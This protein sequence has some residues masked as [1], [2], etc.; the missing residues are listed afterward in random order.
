MTVFV[1]GGA[2]ALAILMAM[3]HIAAAQDDFA[4]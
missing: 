2:A 3:P 1:K 4:I